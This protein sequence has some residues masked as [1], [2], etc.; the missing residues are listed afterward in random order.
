MVPYIN[1]KK[2]S[3]RYDDTVYPPI[4][5]VPLRFAIIKRNEWMVEQSDAVIS[6]VD[7]EAGGAARTLKYAKRKH[8]KIIDLCRMA[9]RLV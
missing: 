8:K 2:Y 3:N 5:N 1:S 9:N 4:E 7:F 6:Y